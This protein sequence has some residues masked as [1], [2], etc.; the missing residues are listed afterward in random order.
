MNPRSKTEK[1]KTQSQNARTMLAISRMIR[2]APAKQDARVDR[3][4]AVADVVPS[5]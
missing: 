5:N 1:A 3:H 2:S 4:R